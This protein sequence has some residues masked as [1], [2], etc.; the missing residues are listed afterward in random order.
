LI[1]DL[2]ETTYRFQK[3]KGMV[4]TYNNYYNRSG[5]YSGYYG[6]GMSNDWVKETADT[7]LSHT[8]Y[9]T[10]P[11]CHKEEVL[12]KD[13]DYEY[14]LD[15]GYEKGD[16]DTS[17]TIIVPAADGCTCDTCGDWITYEGTHLFCSRCKKKYELKEDDVD[18]N[19]T[20]LWDGLCPF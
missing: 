16:D 17:D 7:K 13:T 6:G 14:C 12:W 9:V 5:R 3:P 11:K 18:P 4:L 8:G 20:G 10:C 2:G 1:I 15:C 19:Q